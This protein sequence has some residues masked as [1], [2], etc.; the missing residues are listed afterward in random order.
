M[1]FLRP[2]CIPALIISSYMGNCPVVC[3]VFM[4]LP[5]RS[6]SEGGSVHISKTVVRLQYEA[7]HPSTILPPSDTQVCMWQHMDRRCY[8]AGNSGGNLLK[9]PSLLHRREQDD[10]HARPYR[11][12]LPPRQEIR[13]KS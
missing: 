7:R 3:I 13:G 1:V 2:K 5:V 12:V 4:G 6:F 9:L 11:K 8:H 10:R